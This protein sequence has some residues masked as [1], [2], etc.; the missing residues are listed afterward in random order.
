MASRSPTR[1]TDRHI[2][3]IATAGAA[4]AA[5]AVVSDLVIRRF[6][7]AHP[8]LTSLVA[9]LVVVAI[10][11]AVINEV[12]EAR[13]RRRWSLLAQSVLF[14]LVQSAR[15]TWTTMLEVLELGVVQSG[16]LESLLEGANIALDY[17]RVSAAA[18]ELLADSERRQRLQR[19]MEH[20]NRHASE[21]IAARAGVM[22]GAAPYA[23]LLDRHVELQARLEWV[24]SV[25]AHREPTPDRSW[26]SQALTLSSVATEAADSVDENWLHDM[27][28][29]ITVLATRLDYESR[30]L[31]LSLAPNDWWNERTREIME[32]AGSARMPAPSPTAQTGARAGSAPPDQGSVV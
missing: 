1:R 2:A 28:V 14:A 23:H 3:L 10:S 7:I 32:T 5:L 9:N 12:I 17:G 31:A 18:T 27:I 24:S 26:S 20:L 16:A 8:M 30:D 15:W 19:T 11:I 29:A 21:V 4:L 25:L 13:N 6:W 22:V